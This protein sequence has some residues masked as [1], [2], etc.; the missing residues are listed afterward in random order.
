MSRLLLGG[1]ASVQKK[2]VNPIAG[3]YLLC[4]YLATTRCVWAL[5]VLLLDNLY[6]L[7]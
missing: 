1:G 3:I 4:I 5:V 6:Y 7:L 2:E